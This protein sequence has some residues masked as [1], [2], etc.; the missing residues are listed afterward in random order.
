[1]CCCIPVHA[2]LTTTSLLTAHKHHKP[3]NQCIA[4]SEIEDGCATAFRYTHRSE[5][6]QIPRARKLA[7]L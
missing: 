6:P 2:P 3:T 1:M 5:P 4:E 7:P